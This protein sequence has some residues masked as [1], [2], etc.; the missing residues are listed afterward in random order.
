MKLSPRAV[1]E[2][3]RPLCRSSTST[4]GNTSRKYSPSTFLSTS[5]PLVALC[6]PHP[7]LVL[8]FPHSST[9]S[10]PTEPLPAFNLTTRCFVSTVG[11][12][13]CAWG[14]GHSD[15]VTTGGGKGA[16]KGMPRDFQ[17]LDSSSTFG[18]NIGSEDPNGEPE[19][20]V[21]P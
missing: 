18:A 14:G 3:I 17:W 12:Y 5:S 1:V 10:P 21:A 4:N 15:T 9:T 20:P 7:R 16:S 11:G 2:K 19:S 6:G 13:R 8:V